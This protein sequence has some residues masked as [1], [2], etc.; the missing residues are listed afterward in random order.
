[1]YFD[2]KTRSCFASCI[3]NSKWVWSGNT[4]ITN[5]RQTI[6]NAMKNHTTI[7]RHQQDKPSKS[8]SSL[9]PFKMIAKLEWTYSNVQQN[10]QNIQQLQTLT[11]GVRSTV[12]FIIRAPSVIFWHNGLMMMLDNIIIIKSHG[13]FWL[14]F[15]YQSNAYLCVGR[16]VT[17]YVAC[18]CS[19]NS[20]WS[21]IS[22]FVLDSIVHRFNRKISSDLPCCRR[23]FNPKL[24]LTINCECLWKN[25]GNAFRILWYL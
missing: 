7:T 21:Q 2:D 19:E 25:L 24:Y 11:M 6:G 22:G 20:Y 15:N 17:V 10:L 12:I 14:D 3:I 1:M 8:T 4:T 9:C 5:C 18:Q 23:V 16:K 13:R